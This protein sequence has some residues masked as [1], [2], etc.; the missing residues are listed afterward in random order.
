MWL[1]SRPSALLKAAE[2]ALYRA[3]V[4]ARNQMLL[5]SR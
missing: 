1:S 5:A 3:K 2:D 4:A